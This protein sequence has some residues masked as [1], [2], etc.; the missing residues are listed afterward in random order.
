M[1]PLGFS[2]YLYRA[3]LGSRRPGLAR[4]LDPSRLVRRGCPAASGPAYTGCLATPATLCNAS[5]TSF[6]FTA[7]A[8]LC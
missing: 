5:Q 7:S 1:T 8:V 6:D 3:R 2:S 4:P